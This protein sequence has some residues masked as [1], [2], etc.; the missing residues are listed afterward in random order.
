MNTLKQVLV[1]NIGDNPYCLDSSRI[2]QILTVPSI[3]SLPMVHT[4]VRGL[5]SITGSVT[6]IFDLSS[7]ISDS[8][9]AVDT[10]DNRSRVLTVYDDN[11]VLLSFLV[12][13][14]VNNIIIDESIE[15]DNQNSSSELTDG[16]IKV[17][18]AL[19]QIISFEKLLLYISKLYS[20]PKMYNITQKQ[21]E[22]EHE[23]KADNS[24]PYLIFAMGNEEFALN[25]NMVREIILRTDKI[26]RIADSNAEIMGLITLRGEIILGVDFRMF[27]HTKGFETNHNRFIIVD[28]DGIT[29]GLL[30]DK[31][32]DIKSV[33]ID[34]IE[35]MPEKYKDDR[36]LGVIQ[37]NED[38]IISVIDDETIHNLAK[39]LKSYERDKDNLDDKV[40]EDN[41]RLIPF[42]LLKQEYAFDVDDIDEIINLTDV[43]KIPNTPSFVL[44][45]VNIRGTI[46][47][48][49]SLIDKLN[50][51]GLLKY[52]SNSKILISTVDGIQVGFIVDEV[53]GIIDIDNSNITNNE[54]ESELF[55]EIIIL[56][57]GKRII[58]K[59]NL[60]KIL[61][62]SSLSSLESL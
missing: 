35:D 58:L 56:N 9:M 38:D 10:K 50:L 27:F 48:I 14:V 13:N 2:E 1:F 41:Y 32:I 49:I 11:G 57:K 31:I 29:L 30:V 59:I 40:N 34:N 44:G 6:S 19:I 43:T 21:E 28:L 61:E 24:R 4:I 15:F 37:K 54:E 53:T 5:C 45:I 12:E 20:E 7:I 47:P 18:D 17:D 16:V 36:I 25:T 51:N 46:I 52:T 60:S 3:T 23:V 22:S 33:D 26:T 42:K 55:P 39:S 62:S 8:N